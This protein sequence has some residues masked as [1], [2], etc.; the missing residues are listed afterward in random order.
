M[1]KMETITSLRSRHMRLDQSASFFTPTLGD[2]LRLLTN[3][4]ATCSE[5]LV[6]NNAPSRFL[7]TDSLESLL[8]S[9]EMR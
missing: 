6:H 9:P 1:L 8:M 2:E 5:P 4:G 7:G 3:N